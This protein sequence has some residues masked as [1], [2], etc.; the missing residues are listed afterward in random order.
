MTLCIPERANTVLDTTGT[1][2]RERCSLLSW[3]D[4]YPRDIEYRFNSRGFRDQEWPEDLKSAVWCVG[5]SFTL[6][7]GQPFEETWCQRLGRRAINISMDGASNEWITQQVLALQYQYGPKHIAIHW[8]FI[9][10][11]HGVAVNDLAARQHYVNSTVAEDVE[12][13]EQCVELVNRAAPGAIHTIIPHAAPDSSLDAVQARWGIW[14]PQQ[15]DVGR[16]HYHYG[17]RTAQAIADYVV[18][19]L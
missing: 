17:P 12:N 3:F 2:T 18:S 10:R 15:V 5:D 19:R 1:D 7:I 8:S 13:F 6:G 16:D 9:H 14:Q 4:Q 11:R